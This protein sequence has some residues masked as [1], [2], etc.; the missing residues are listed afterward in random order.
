MLLFLIFLI[1]LYLLTVTYLGSH[2]KK[3]FLIHKNKH[4]SSNLSTLQLNCLRYFLTIKHLRKKLPLHKFPKS[5]KEIDENKKNNEFWASMSIY[6]TKKEFLFENYSF[7]ENLENE[8]FARYISKENAK[9]E[10]YKN[11]KSSYDII[12]KKKIQESEHKKL[13]LQLTH[14]YIL[15][16]L[17]QSIEAI[18]SKLKKNIYFYEYASPSNTATYTIK[19]NLTRKY[20]KLTIDQ[21]FQINLY[22]ES[23]YQ[24]VGGNQY[25]LHQCSNYLNYLNQGF[26]IE[27]FGSSLN[28][29]LP[30]FGSLS[31][32]DEPCG[33]LGTYEEILSILIAKKDLFWHDQLVFSKSDIVKITINPPS[34]IKLHIHL[35]NLL[36]DLFATRKTIIILDL[37][38]STV[39]N[40]SS[41]NDKLLPFEKSRK[42]TTRAF[43][44]NTEK[45][46]QMPWILFT[47]S[48]L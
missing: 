43:Y 15:S 16:N 26:K 47:L 3:I 40:D 42:K 13:R 27:L 48:N 6:F 10:S 24:F 25:S 14:D 1:F 36:A 44:L 45:T 22:Y 5:E 8:N 4:A 33:R 39:L 20:N 41:Y 21:K 46:L 9:I 30:Y 23:I 31:S 32:I 17:K 37:P 38:E 11:D 29:S 2:E 35:I 34:H 12:I 18:N 28:T 19:N 7:L